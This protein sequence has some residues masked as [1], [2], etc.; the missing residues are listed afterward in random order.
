MRLCISLTI[1]L[2]LAALAPTS[3]PTAAPATQPARKHLPR[4]ARLTIG[5]LPT[6]RLKG[7]PH[8]FSHGTGATI[9]LVVGAKGGQ[10]SENGSLETARLN[11]EIVDA[12]IRKR[13]ETAEEAS[14]SPF[15][16]K[17]D[18]EFSLLAQ[19]SS[20]G[21]MSCSFKKRIEFYNPD[22]RYLFKSDDGKYIYLAT[23]TTEPPRDAVHRYEI[24]A[25][26]IDSS[27]TP[28][29]NSNT[30]SPLDDLPEGFGKSYNRF[31]V[32]K[33]NDDEALATGWGL[34]GIDPRSCSLM[35]SAKVLNY[36]NGG[37][38]EVE[39]T[40]SLRK[41]GKATF[42]DVGTTTLFTRGPT[43][44]P[45]KDGRHSLLMMLKPDR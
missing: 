12:R 23:W 43:I 4:S 32:D 41:D 22:D 5:V 20:D 28:T 29:P 42:K 1:T 3:Q 25:V 34:A 17:I 38:I 21:P 16:V 31:I 27:G 44:V 11:M 8:Q 13:P 35:F 36:V 30:H 18:V 6:A 45:L 40:V 9:E 19:D 37:Q 14:A 24:S 2:L 15:P 26:I 10:R 39:Y 7:E 33:Y